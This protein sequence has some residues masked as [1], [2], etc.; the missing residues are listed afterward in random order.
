VGNP[1]SETIMIAKIFQLS[2]TFPVV[3]FE[4]FLGS[5]ACNDIFS[6][7]YERVGHGDVGV[8]VQD[9]GQ[10]RAHKGA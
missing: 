3:K 9:E 10:R 5:I 8:G 2:P 4:D 7:L 6:W 1:V